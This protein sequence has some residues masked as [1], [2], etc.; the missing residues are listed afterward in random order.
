MKSVYRSKRSP[1]AHADS[2]PVNNTRQY[3]K[4]KEKWNYILATNSWMKETSPHR[5][6]QSI[7]IFDYPFV[8]Y[9]LMTCEM[10]FF[11]PIC[12]LPVICLEVLTKKNETSNESLSNTGCTSI[13]AKN[14]ALPAVPLTTIRR[15]DSGTPRPS[16][17]P[18]LGFDHKRTVLH[19]D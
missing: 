17:P 1:K 6:Q 13:S 18:L 8:F 15:P 16:L 12:F 11:Y 4:E 7:S 2:I 3:K 19:S 10:D 5:Q 9:L 14:T